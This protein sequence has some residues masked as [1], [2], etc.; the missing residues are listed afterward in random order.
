M[1]LYDFQLEAVDEFKRWYPSSSREAL[2][3]LTVGLGKTVTASA[4][5]DHVIKSDPKSQVLWLTHRKELI[6]QSSRQLSDYVG[7][8]C[9]IEQGERRADHNARILVASVDT[10]RGKR[11][12]LLAE[13]FNPSLILNDEAHHALAESWMA[14]KGVFGLAK[15][16]NLT[17]TPYRA[18]VSKRLDLGEL[19]IERTVSDGIRMGM[20]VPPVPGGSLNVDLGDVGISLGDY[21]QDSL[22]RLLCVPQVVGES[23]ELIVSKLGDRR[24]LIFAA[25]VEHGKLLGAGLRDRGCAV[26]EVYGDTPMETRRE[27]FARLQQ[28][29]VQLIINN[30]VLTEGFNRPFMNFIGI[31]RPTQ[32]AALYVQ[33]LGRGLRACPKTGKRDCLVLD[34]LDR[35]KQLHGKSGEL[36]MPDENDRRKANSLEGRA[37]PLAR[38]FVSWFQKREELKAGV[39]VVARTVIRS[40]EDLYSAVFSQSFGRWLAVQ[41]QAISNLHKLWEARPP[42]SEGDPEGYDLLFRELRCGKIW[43]F[44]KVMIDRGWVY[45]PRGQVP[46]MREWGKG[47]ERPQNCNFKALFGS[48]AP[49]QNFIMDVLG[50]EQDIRSRIGQCFTEIMIDGG[51]TYWMRPYRHQGFVFINKDFDYLVRTDSGE[52]FHFSLLR[53][54]QWT[55]KTMRAGRASLPSFALSSAWCHNPVTHKQAVQ[56]RKLFKLTEADFVALQGELS[57]MVA[58]SLISN[59]FGKSQLAWISRWLENHGGLD[60]ARNAPEA[61]GVDASVQSSERRGFVPVGS[62][63]RTRAL[64]TEDVTAGESGQQDPGEVAWS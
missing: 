1:K 39:E 57:R 19:L 64:V 47:A 9:S 32:N 59:E 42:V 5:V 38:I 40:G 31:F 36:D 49:L 21:E 33:M 34:V 45:C 4:C 17:A 56:L 37:L 13:R 58:S 35:P 27:Y 3:A 51:N 52:C 41:R 43:E 46:D 61:D 53:A 54:G 6:D 60:E 15:V 29:K 23:V 44:M 48:D 62:G 18:D 26:A 63:E 12:H 25:S 24:G 20:L 28:G 7:L 30:L 10:L 22:S 50:G 11:L 14:V 8:P 55:V 16:L 2:I